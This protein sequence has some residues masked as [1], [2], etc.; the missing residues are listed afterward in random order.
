MKLIGT[1]MA[2]NESD[3]I[4]AFVRHN[5]RFLDALV[6]LDHGSVDDSPDILAALGREG[7]AIEVLRDPVRAFNQGAR[8]TEMARRYLRGTQAE[9]CFALDA[10]EF[11][12]APSR[13]ALQASLARLPPQAHGSVALQNYLGST[14]PLE[15]NP[16]LRHT[17]RLGDDRVGGH[18]V[19]LRRSFADDPA[20]QVALGN[21]AA[22]R[23]EQG[24]AR[25]FAH[26]IVE[27]VTLAHFP[28]RSAEQVATKAII[29]WLSHRLTRPER[30]LGNMQGK[31]IP[32]SHW[33]ELFDMISSGRVE[34]GPALLA[35]ATA[36]YGGP[37]SSGTGPQAL[38]EDPVGCDFEL[39]YTRPIAA[40]PLAILAAWT[41]QLVTDVNAARPAGQ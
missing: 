25:P 11:I 40:S 31:T 28:V 3:V 30:F 41:D 27:G 4:E 7:L 17:T 26:A 9:F 39:R 15:I 16:L 1:C 32:A 8:Q 36:A 29:G 18:K 22:V 24:A 34:V 20:A 10:D 19:V 12:R 35:E 2:R 5:L 38:V 33:R 14:H 23:V 13:E 37:S 21:H 6:V